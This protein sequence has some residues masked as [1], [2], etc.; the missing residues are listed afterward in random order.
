MIPC[1]LYK[2]A[3]QDNLD[4]TWTVMKEMRVVVPGW[5]EPFIV[6][7]GFITDYASVPRLLWS[8]FPPNGQ[9]YGVAAIVH[10]LIYRNLQRFFTR[11]QADHILFQ[12]MEIYGTKRITRWCIWLGV[13]LGGASAW[14]KNKLIFNQ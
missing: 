7:E 3:M 13:R 1:E 10:D 9:R 11:K 14:S 5:P 12:V 8:I 4:G 2:P 6:P